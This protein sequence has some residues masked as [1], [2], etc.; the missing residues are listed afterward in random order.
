M[1]RYA[2]IALSCLICTHTNLTLDKND[3]NCLR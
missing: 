2:Y 3:E 1:D